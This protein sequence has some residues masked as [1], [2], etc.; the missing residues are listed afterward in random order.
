MARHVTKSNV[1]TLAVMLLLMGL[2]LVQTLGTS[3]SATHEPANKVSAAG[4][5]AVVSAPGE[6]VTLLSEVVKT[7]KPTDLILSVTLECVITTE[8]TTVGNDSQSAEARVRVWVEIDG[9]PVPVS[10]DDTTETGKVT[11]CDRLE[12]RET[13]LF[14]D[15][16]ATIRTLVRTGHAEGFNW[17]ALDVGSATH[18]IEVHAQLVTSATDGA[19]ALAA[20]G[21]RT[22][23]VEPTKSANDEAVTELG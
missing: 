15:E 18:T 3:A 14:D 4:S 5:T 13:T 1:T 12:E 16:D 23:I 11:F 6:D 9:T 17:M 22:L 19:E 20:V 8:L 21:K 2:L 10:T 7:S